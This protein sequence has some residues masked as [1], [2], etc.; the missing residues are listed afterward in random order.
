MS[1]MVRTGSPALLSPVAAAL[2][3]Q[4]HDDPSAPLSVAVCAPGGYGKSALLREIAA[5]YRAAG[6]PVGT[7]WQPAGGDPDDS[8]LLVDDAHLVDDERLRDLVR[9]AD[10]PGARVIVAYR[11]WPRPAGLAAL[12]EVLRRRQTPVSL[13]PLGEDQ[14][15]ARC[16]E[17]WE[18]P[19]PAEWIRFLLVQSGGVPRYLDRLVTG[20]AAGSG[21]AGTP[22]ERAPEPALAPFAADLDEVDADTLTVLLA[23]EAG[24]GLSLTVVAALLDRDPE[25][26]TALLATA[27]ATGMLAASGAL[28]PLARQALA[29]H[30]PVAQ[31]IDIRRRMAE[32]QLA[33]G[34]SVLPLMRSLLALLPQAGP[35]AP[36]DE[37]SVALAPGAQATGLGDA[38]LA[39]GDE[40]LQ[41][42]PALAAQLFD[43]ASRAG[44][45]AG[46]RR[47]L[48]SA[49]A[50]D[51]EL[52]SLLADQVLAT[53]PASQ[54]PDAACVAAAT[55]AHRN[56]L[57][58][59][60]EL[61]R[62]A[63]PRLAAG[64]GTVGLIG[65]GHPE[66]AGKLLSATPDDP[67]A[68]P[69]TLLSTAASGMARGAY[70]SVQGSPMAALSALV[71]AAQLLE[72][73]GSAVL[74]PD[75]PAALAAL[76]ALHCAEFQSA[77][78]VLERALETNLG[79]PLFVRRHRLL[80]AWTAMAQGRLAAAAELAALAGVPTGPGAEPGPAGAPGRDLVFAAA[81]RA[82]LARRASDIAGLQAS[83]PQARQSLIGQ[84]VDLYTLLPLGEIA[85]AAARLGETRQ[86]RPALL[87]ADDLL[88]RLGEPVLWSAPLHWSR[89]HAAI[90]AD[91]RPAVER[92]V[93][94][95]RERRDDSAYAAALAAAGQCWLDMLSDRIEPD[96]VEA[97]A[98]GLAELGL[99]WDGARLA[100]Q[101]AIR[102]TD[103]KAMTLLL[104]CARS[105][106]ARQAPADGP[107]TPGRRGRPGQAARP[108]LSD[109]EEEVAALV[110][111]GLT[112]KQVADRLYISA[113][114]VEHHMARIRQRLG[115]ADRGELL[116]QLRLIV[117][118]PADQEAPYGPEGRLP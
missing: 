59:S 47:A 50:G 30:G 3:A 77:Q 89:L 78:T 7:L 8:V 52:A 86:V 72:P 13:P 117:R 48:A 109:R 4:V 37:P 108:V 90:L 23:V 45:P 93:G 111:A 101:A 118:V 105:L 69:P 94:A 27:K 87:A 21:V 22:L 29:M 6:V 44:H 74:L 106:Q 38:F 10:R 88:G 113:K 98:R 107:A 55:L 103:R 112:Y 92:H 24:A 91:E 58:R 66:A 34:G 56:Q 16:A 71:Q 51:L 26:A 67:S 2:V 57:A 104:D 79:G 53:G 15:R 81:L 40:A 36:E 100:G 9:L 83:W 64:F 68:G 28:V 85:V 82:G 49:L 54:R 97:A 39:A 17:L 63:T 110:L 25:Q 35:E 65:T 114:T 115:S 61:Y 76:V 33:R 116:A 32:W 31:R 42:D 73:S 75:S 46:A 12:T 41:G 11:P 102:T 80:L 60:V 14:V 96:A 99:S 20:L 95:L 5:G 84:P 70:E 1:P 43:A 62:W 19:V 18:H